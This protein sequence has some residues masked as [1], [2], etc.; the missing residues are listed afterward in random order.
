MQVVCL[1]R[2]GHDQVPTNHCRKDTFKIL[3]TSQEQVSISLLVVGMSS[4]PLHL[5]AATTIDRS[6]EYYLT[7]RM[8]LMVRFV[9][10]GVITCCLVV[11]VDRVNATVN[12]SVTTTTRSRSSLSFRQWNKSSCNTWQTIRGGGMSIRNKKPLKTNKVSSSST[13]M[14]HMT[15]MISF[16]GRTSVAALME[17]VTLL[18]VLR[19]S[20]GFVNWLETKNGSVR[21]FGSNHRHVFS[22][23]A[24]FLIVFASSAFGALI[25][26]STAA[27]QQALKPSSIPTSQTQSQM[28]SS[29][30]WYSALV[31]PKWEPPG[32]V[33]PIMWLLI[34]KP[35]QLKALTLLLSTDSLSSTF[36]WTMAFYCFH[37][38]LGDAWN[39][40]FF[41]YQRIGEGVVVITTFYSVL[42]YSAWRFY[43]LHST[44]AGYYMIP[45]ILWVTVATALNWRIYFLNK[46]NKRKTQEK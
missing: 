40:V 26:G 41:G 9:W 30:N 20:L 34:S 16:T 21:R 43:K 3:M 12:D 2:L 38:S 5:H 15:D 18:A 35:T 14:V 33:F 7:N 10:F 28:S 4:V 37:L 19:G 11:V 25:D 29:E 42:C 36:W 8:M 31:R 1:E 17:S 24:C 22:L 27:L 13:T 32:W 23:V 39:K 44:A 46:E 45:T 6:L